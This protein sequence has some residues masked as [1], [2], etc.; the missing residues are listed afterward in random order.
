MEDWDQKNNTISSRGDV[1]AKT[2]HSMQQLEGTGENL[3]TQSLGKKYHC[4]TNLICQESDTSI[5]GWSTTGSNKTS[6]KRNRTSNR[7]LN[8][9]ERFSSIPSKRTVS[10]KLLKFRISKSQTS[11]QKATH[12]SSE[13]ALSTIWNPHNLAETV[14][15]ILLNS[16]SNTRQ[17]QNCGKKQASADQ[18]V[19]HRLACHRIPR[20]EEENP[21]SSSKDQNPKNPI[22]IPSKQQSLLKL[23]AEEDLAEFIAEAKD[24]LRRSQK[25]RQ[26]KKKTPLERLT[27]K[28]C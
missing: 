6:A 26:W 15:R 16:I 4:K 9:L 28:N 21:D 3:Q 11:Y 23:N 19:C 27:T 17:T 25:P 13:G 2:W 5:P 22:P 20:K 12:S 14:M 1:Q 24:S 18:H 8:F 10:S 7:W